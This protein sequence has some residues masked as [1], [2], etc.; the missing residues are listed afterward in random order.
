MKP[1]GNRLE[2]F[3]SEMG[4][5][6]D[7]ARDISITA[8]EDFVASALD[9]KKSTVIL[10]YFGINREKGE[11]SRAI[12]LEFGINEKG[13][14]SLRKSA[15]RTLKCP[16]QRERLFALMRREEESKK[17]LSLLLGIS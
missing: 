9:Q 11:S 8:V 7:E 3:F 6:P 2:K 1:L 5:S 13:V 4:I 10:R 12:G 15:L 14:V 17:I 16:A